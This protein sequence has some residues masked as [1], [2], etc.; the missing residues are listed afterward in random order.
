MTSISVA[1]DGDDVM[2]AL[3]GQTAVAAG[4]RHDTLVAY[5]A[6]TSNGDVLLGGDGM[7]RLINGGGVDTF[8]GGAMQTASF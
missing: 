7:D 6:G 8:T 3:L 2:G 1:T 5:S 4:D